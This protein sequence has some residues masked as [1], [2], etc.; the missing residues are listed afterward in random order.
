MGDFDRTYDADSGLDALVPA[1]LSNS[2][3][4]RAVNVAGCNWCSIAVECVGAS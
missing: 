4:E 1:R 2:I 3:S